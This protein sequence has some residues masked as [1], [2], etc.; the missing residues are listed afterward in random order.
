[1]WLFATGRHHRGWWKNI[2]FIFQLYISVY[3]KSRAKVIIWGEINISNINM[4]FL[5]NVKITTTLILYKKVRLKKSENKEN[6]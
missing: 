2:T 3:T 6:I 4:I 5:L 1:M